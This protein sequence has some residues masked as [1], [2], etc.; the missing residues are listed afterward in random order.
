MPE[1]V[2]G[3]RTLPGGAAH[4]SRWRDS[5]GGGGA[6]LL[7]LAGQPA[8]AAPD[9]AREP[10]SG[11]WPVLLLLLGTLLTVAIIHRLLQRPG[12]R[13]R[14]GIAGD[15]PRTA[16]GKRRRAQA[17]LLERR[18]VEAGDLYRAA[19]E[20]RAALDAYLQGDA[21]AQS[22]RVLEDLGRLGEAAQAYEQ[23]GLPAEAARLWIRSGQPAAAARCL[24][25]AGQLAEAA[26]L[27]KA[28]GEPARAAAALGQQGNRRDAALALQ[29]AGQPAQAAE[30]L[31]EL[32][33]EL[34]R[35]SRG[36]AP[37]A[38]V[39]E[40]ALRAGRLFEAAE[41]PERAIE[42]YRA[43]QVTAEAVRLLLARGRPAEA[44][45]LLV[46]A[47]REEEALPL[48]E[49]GGEREQVLRIKVRQAQ[50]RGDLLTAAELLQKLGEKHQA[51]TILRDGGHPKE[52]ARL[53][54]ACQDTLSAAA[55]YEEAGDLQ[56]AA[57]AHEQAGNYRR[58]EELYRQLGLVADR[59]RM[60][61]Q[62]G[63]PLGVAR[64]LL[65]QQRDAEATTLLQTIGSN[66]QDH[67]AACWLLGEIFQRAG[68][69]VAAA[70]KLRQSLDGIAA[71]TSNLGQFYTLGLVAG[72]A[73][74]LELARSALEAVLEVDP[75]YRDVR[76][77]L[78][79]LSSPT[80]P[81]P[82]EDEEAVLELT[83][84]AP[85]EPPPD[86]PGPGLRRA[87]ETAGAPPA[88]RG[89]PR[90]AA[91]AEVPL[92]V[93]LAAPAR[94][95]AAPSPP[96]PA[97]RYE[98]RELIGKGGL[99]EVYRAHDRLLDREVAYKR[100]DRLPGLPADR[101][102]EEA[103][104]AAKLNHPN[105]ITLFDAGEEDGHPFLTMELVEGED[106]ASLVAA[107][108]PLGLRFIGAILRQVC[109]GLAYAHEKG[110]VHRDIKPAN[111]MWTVE[112]TLKITDF[113]LA[114]F[115]DDQKKNQEE[116]SQIMGTPYYMSPEQILGE[117][118]DARTDIYSLGISLFELTTGRVPFT[119]RI[120]YQHI[121]DNPPVPSSLRSDCPSWL[122]QVILWCLK[123]DRRRRPATVRELWRAV[124]QEVGS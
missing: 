93:T 116:K 82:A 113:G 86:A 17:L 73:G 119:E 27:W 67:R 104:A 112:G 43:H 118:L 12:P 95:P 29:Q 7:L 102:L 94:P 18:F 46:Q 2:R 122:D 4:R 99:A 37:R 30:V 103:R 77:R 120:I 110:L 101:F 61:Q 109:D 20:A 10:G 52:A 117:T 96:L 21:P 84:P 14:A 105:I 72:A 42:V 6:L 66:S 22:A 71:G 50:R 40:V 64:L 115:L 49:R 76:Q 54:L 19:G 111:M 1:S 85:T 80:G 9:T 26:R 79:Q 97:R 114:K 33:A 123:K 78:E 11:V 68:D 62:L 15:S 59:L 75:R 38:E 13:A 47:G 106:L 44:G 32:L 8:L 88:S 70:I 60:L 87:G 100:L 58:A 3:P 31:L 24:E 91:L 65:E 89:D 39:Q 124:A 45:A 35:E 16:F 48:L 23:A 36:G 63:D 34:S 55:C 90:L 25:A 74:Q 121:Q 5:L 41:L 98:L 107:R 53:F 57:A 51:A 83:T 108:G 69:P 81:G 28:A 92:D 56:G